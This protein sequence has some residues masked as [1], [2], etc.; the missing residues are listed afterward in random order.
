MLNYCMICH[1]PI[2]NE[3][4][5]IMD[6]SNNVYHRHCFH[7]TMENYSE[8]LEIGT[9]KNVKEKYSFIFNSPQKMQNKPKSFMEN[10][11]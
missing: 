7:L 3:N 5:V 2:E 11:I 8:I 10:R 6:H 1:S 4:S 9:F